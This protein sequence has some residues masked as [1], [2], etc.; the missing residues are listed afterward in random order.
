V[1][2]DARDISDNAIAL[3]SIKPG[4]SLT[5]EA[6]SALLRG[7]ANNLAFETGN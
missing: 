2:L 6:A 4:S 5:S 7:L 3:L 1:A